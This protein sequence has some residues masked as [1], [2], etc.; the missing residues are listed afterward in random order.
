MYNDLIKFL[1]I[2]DVILVSSND[3]SSIKFNESD[4]ACDAYYVKMK[5]LLSNISSQISSIH[6]LSSSLRT[7][8]TNKEKIN[9]NE[10]KKNSADATHSHLMNA[11]QKAMLERDESHAQIVATS[12]LHVHDLE[13]ERKKTQRF[14]DKLNIVLKRLFDTE[15][16]AN[17]SYFQSNVDILE[18]LRIKQ[19]QELKSLESE[20]LEN[21]DTELL[22]LCRQLASEIKARTSSTL[23]VNRLKELH[24]HET[25]IIKDENEKLRRELDMAKEALKRQQE[26]VQIARAD[27]I[28]W[29]SAFDDLSK[30]N[31]IMNCD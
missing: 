19:Q 8:N 2:S 24:N 15:A 30:K 3:S 27:Q 23:E 11:L 22:S 10:E 9:E 17:A 26:E 16:A 31:L 5:G 20:L 7:I 6:S 21:N 29:K 12:V 14:T 28:S 25:K 18:S 13:Q 4:R 1:D